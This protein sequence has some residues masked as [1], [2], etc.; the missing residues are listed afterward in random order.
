MQDATRRDWLSFEHEGETY[1]FDLTF[2][3]SNWQCIFGR[4]CRGIHETDTTELGH[5]CCSHGAY[6]ADKADRR[7]VRD[8][9][10]SLT[11]EQWQF[12]ALA[13]DLGGAITRND[14]GDWVTRTHDGACIMLN[15]AE[16]PRG[17]GCALH[18][19]A[20]DDGVSHVGYKPEVCWQLP[21]RLTFH[22]DEVDH[23]TYTLREWHRRDWGEGGEEFRWWC[24]EGREA[25]T[26]HDRVVDSLREEIIGLVGDGVYRRLL[27]EMDRASAG[28]PVS[29]PARR[30]SA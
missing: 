25:F 30:V 27:A 8:A 17:P 11:D 15:R 7:R 6:F 2:L 28:T 9:I 13:R 12:R 1:L 19:A 3:S 18:V 20:I 29:H 10:G 24:T 16:H 14:D 21:L 23:T 5:G 22:T 26:S 4:G